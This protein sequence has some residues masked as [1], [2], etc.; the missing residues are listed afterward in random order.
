M[1]NSEGKAVLVLT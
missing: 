1:V